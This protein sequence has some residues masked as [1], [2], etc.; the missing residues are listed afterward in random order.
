MTTAARSTATAA[1]RPHDTAR[2]TAVA[3]DGVTRRFGETTAL[4][5]VALDIAAGETVAL[6]GP[7][8]AGKTTAIGIMLGLIEPSAGHART[9]GLTPHDAVRSGRVGAMLQSAGLPPGAR[10]GELIDLARGLYPHPS[11]RDAILERAGLTD[12]VG[13]RAETLSG[14][15][16]QRVRFAFAI[17]GDPDLVFLDEPTVA[18]DVESR[19]AFWDDMRRFAAEGR[20]VL[21][22]TH[23]LDEADHIADR[24]V[25]L[26]RGRIVGDGSPSALKATVTERTVRFSLA[27]DP[28]GDDALRALPGVVGL[29]RHGDSMALLSRD[30]DETVRGL[31][32]A[33]VAFRH[34]EVAGADLD[35]AFLALTSEGA[36]GARSTSAASA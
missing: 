9:L 3:F 13:R 1:D 35:A 6:L 14:G 24:I 4:D 36:R 20:T 22:A 19:R 34:L 32:A 26:D 5:D 27:G 25:V 7:N 10:V 16:A 18:M 31:V 30:A 28:S 12:L 11:P 15:E 8:G 23:Y 2:P 17:A 33:G 21:F 29:D